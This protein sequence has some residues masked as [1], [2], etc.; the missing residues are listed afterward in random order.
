MILRVCRKILKLLRSPTRTSRSSP[1]RRADG[2]LSPELCWIGARGASPSCTCAKNS[3]APEERRRDRL[4]REEN[5][6]LLPLRCDRFLFRSTRVCRQH[7]P[8]RCYASPCSCVYVGNFL[9]L[10]RSLTPP[11]KAKATGIGS[12]TTG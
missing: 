7:S 6:R 8:P 12:G 9:K 1:R 11:G 4:D 10:L 3:G 2:T 5:V